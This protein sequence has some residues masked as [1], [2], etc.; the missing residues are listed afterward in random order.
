M[1]ERAVLS[2]RLPEDLHQALKRVAEREDRSLNNLIV[3]LLKQAV[4]A[5]GPL[6]APSR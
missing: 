5:M 4:E 1:R 6:D 2:V 3:H